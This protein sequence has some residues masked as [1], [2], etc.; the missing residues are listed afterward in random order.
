MVVAQPT[1]SSPATP[2]CCDDNHVKPVRSLHLA[3]LLTSR[4][5]S[6][7]TCEG[8]GHQSL[9]AFFE[10]G[11]HEI[12]D[13]LGVSGHDPWRYRFCWRQASEYFPSFSVREIY[14]GFS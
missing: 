8:L 9:M 10:R 6:V 7:I 13:D 1:Y 14:Q 11:L 12:V 5:W 4:T 2:I 3:P